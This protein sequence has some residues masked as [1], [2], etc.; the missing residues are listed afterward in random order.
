MKKILLILVAMFAFGVQNVN[1][2]DAPLKIVTN[3]PDFDIKVKRC[4]A[5]GKTLIIDLVATNVGTEVID[6]FYIM[7]TN[8]IAYD[9][10]GNVYEGGDGYVGVK[11]A[12]Q[13]QYA[14]VTITNFVE[15]KHTKLLPNIPCK[16][17][18]SLK[19]FAVEATSVG[20]LEL[21]AECKAFN[22]DSYKGEQRIKIHNIP[23]SRK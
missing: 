13:P 22:L 19:G 2:Q 8:C 3:H 12:N 5:S 15:T 1:A 21:G 7:P 11:V 4:A 20:L 17:S 14:F 18:V 16:I 6:D 10:D 9:D 23:V